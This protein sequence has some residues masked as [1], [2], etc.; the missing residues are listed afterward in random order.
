MPLLPPKW[1]RGVRR[2]SEPGPDPAAPF[3]SLHPFPE[4]D[5]C[6]AAAGLCGHSCAG[7]A[8]RGGRPGAAGLCSSAEPLPGPARPRS[9]GQGGAGEEGRGCRAPQAG[10]EG[11]T[12]RG[13]GAGA[14]GERRGERARARGRRGAGSAP[15]LGR[16]DAI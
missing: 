5:S 9:A 2:V 10:T 16:A 12:R 3:P 14:G 13:G 7:R 4:W 11:L 6:G 15:G 8:A 1:S